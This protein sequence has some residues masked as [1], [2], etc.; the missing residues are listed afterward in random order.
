MGV[1]GLPKTVTRQRR[2]CDLNLGPSAPESSTLTTRLPSA[3]FRYMA[4]CSSV[5]LSQVGFPSKLL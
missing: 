2:G 4:L 3:V 1:N 5:C